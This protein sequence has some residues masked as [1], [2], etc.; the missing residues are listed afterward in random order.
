MLKRIE[1]TKDRAPGVRI[2]IVAS[3]YNRKQVDGLVDGAR[4]VLAQAGAEVEILR[5]PGAF[6]IPVAVESL[7]HTRADRP[8]AVI[9]LGV[10]IRG[11]TAHADLVG[12]SVTQALMEISVRHRVPVIHEVLLVA[13]QRQADARCFDPKHNRGGEAANTAL[14]MARLLA[15]RGR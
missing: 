13:N 8:A 3:E 5:V 11:E 15:R 12:A 1:K 7:L 2:A 14:A 9:A 10:I 4:H 6:E